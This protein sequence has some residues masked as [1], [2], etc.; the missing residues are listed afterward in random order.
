MDFCVHLASEVIINEIKENPN[1]NFVMSPLSWYYLITPGNFINKN[2]IHMISIR[3]N[4]FYASFEGFKILKLL[5]E[6]LSNFSIYTFLPVKLDGLQELMQNFNSDQSMLLEKNLKLQVVKLS[7]MWVS[8]FKLSYGFETSKSMEKLGLELPFKLLGDF[9]K[10]LNEEGTEAAPAAAACVLI[11]V[12]GAR[13]PYPPP[14]LPLFI[15]DHHMIMF[16][17]LELFSNLRKIRSNSLF[18]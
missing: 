18:R 12:G 3:E 15:A 8:K 11:M 9:L 7:K 16:C 1:K 13:Q 5:S 2:T 17:L 6:Q 10:W 4:Y 14:P